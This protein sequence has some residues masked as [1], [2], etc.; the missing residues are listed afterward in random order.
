MFWSKNNWVKRKNGTVI[1]SKIMAA[2]E[3]Q[4]GRRGLERGPTQIHLYFFNIENNKGG[5]NKD[6]QITS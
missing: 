1:G 4:N 3:P 5:A 6:P 2:I